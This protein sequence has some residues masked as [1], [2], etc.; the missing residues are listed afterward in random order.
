MHGELFVYQGRHNLN[1]GN[2][3]PYRANRG[4][5]YIQPVTFNVDHAVRYAHDEGE[6]I[7]QRTEITL[8]KQQKIICTEEEIE[9]S[10]KGNQA[11]V[12]YK[13]KNQTPP[14]WKKHSWDLYRKEKPKYTKVLQS[15]DRKGHRIGW[16]EGKEC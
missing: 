10:R 5:I 4:H 1:T 12:L 8:L 16:R 15:S 2:P 3:N 13:P 7:P 9:T 11:H 14:N 6:E